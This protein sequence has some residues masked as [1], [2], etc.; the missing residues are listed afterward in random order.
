MSRFTLKW[1]DGQYKVSKPEIDT[2]DVVSAADF[3][4]LLDALAD[5]LAYLEDGIGDHESEE[6]KH[7]RAL[8][9]KHRGEV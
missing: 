7:A 9:A 6:G 3:D 2:L 4:E 5:L 8:I 1:V